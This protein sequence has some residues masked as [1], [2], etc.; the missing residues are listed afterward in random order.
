MSGLLD[1]NGQ[2]LAEQKQPEQQLD[3][4]LPSWCQG[5]GYRGDDDII[6]LTVVVPES[7]QARMH[8]LKY[9][10]EPEQIR[11]LIGALEKCLKRSESTVLDVSD[12][13]SE[14]SSSN[15]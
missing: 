3:T 11:A 8:L 2:P 15:R 1:V 7:P 13:D 9:E 4:G 6:S 10:S 14:P 12:Q 5:V